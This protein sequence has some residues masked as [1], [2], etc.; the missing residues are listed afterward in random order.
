MCDR[1]PDTQASQAV[2]LGKSARNQQVWVPPYERDAVKAQFRLQVL[3][4]RLVQ[5]DS[6]PGAMPA[7]NR[8]QEGFDRFARKERPCRVIRVGDID[9]TRVWRDGVK[10]RVQIVPEV[11]RGHHD[12]ARATR[13]RG[14]AINNKRMP[15]ID[16][17]NA[18]LEQRKRNDLEYVV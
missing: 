5:H 4:V 2:G 9:K 11:A 8:S 14:K 13:L 1:E 16:D 18:R 15:G 3:V 7:C 12:V 10:H 6:H 17:G